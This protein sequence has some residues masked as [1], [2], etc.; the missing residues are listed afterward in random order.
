MIYAR[1]IGWS[2]L[3]LI[4]GHLLNLGCGRTAYAAERQGLSEIPK[5]SSGRKVADVGRLPSKD[6]VACIEVAPTQSKATP[7]KKKTRAHFAGIK[8]PVQNTS[9]YQASERSSKKSRKIKNQW[10]R[11]KTQ[12]KNRSSS[13]EKKN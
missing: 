3:F 9:S 11:S 7:K 6:S 12:P 10:V 8:R 1:F 2:S 13:R 4:F 5:G